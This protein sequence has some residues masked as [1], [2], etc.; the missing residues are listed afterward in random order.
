[1]AMSWG[2]AETSGLGRRLLDVA[3]GVG[4]AGQLG[5]EGEQVK[6]AYSEPPIGSR[7]LSSV[8]GRD[9]EA[10]GGGGASQATIG[11]VQGCPGAVSLGTLGNPHWKRAS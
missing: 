2:R 7:P 10:G 8:F 1:M 4:G 5:D 11:K 3:A 6:A 9:S